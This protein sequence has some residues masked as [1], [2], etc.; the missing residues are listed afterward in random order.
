MASVK[1]ERETLKIRIGKREGHTLITIVGHNPHWSWKGTIKEGF[2]ILKAKPD[3]DKVHI[4]DG[5]TE[6]RRK[7]ENP[8]NSTRVVLNCRTPDQWKEFQAVK[9]R[10][11][12][13]AVDPHIFVDLLIWALSLPSDN[14][15][16]ARI[17]ETGAER[18]INR[19]SGRDSGKEDEL[20][21]WARE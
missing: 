6:R 17:D 21:A 4:V 19:D 3:G 20:P 1:E 8:N 2:E 16:Q 12:E 5:D 10:Y 15:L 9:E 13:I 18:E 14:E 11:M 7:S